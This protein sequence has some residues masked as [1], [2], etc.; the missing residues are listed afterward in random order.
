MHLKFKELQVHE[1]NAIFAEP[2]GSVTESSFGS[3]V[4]LPSEEASDCLMGV[5]GLFE[6]QVSAKSK[7]S[8]AWFSTCIRHCPNLV[9]L[10][11]LVISFMQNSTDLT[12]QP[13][14]DKIAS[15]VRIDLDD[16]LIL[17]TLIDQVPEYQCPEVLTAVLRIANTA[18]ATSNVLTFSNLCMKRYDF[19]SPV[20]TEE[21][22]MPTAL[23]TDGRI[24]VSDE[25]FISGKWFQLSTSLK[26]WFRSRHAPEPASLNP[27][28]ATD[29]AD[30]WGTAW[31][32]N[33]KKKGK[34]KEGKKVVIDQ[35]AI[36]KDAILRALEDLSTLLSSPLFSKC[37]QGLLF[38]LHRC[39]FFNGSYDRFLESML[40]VRLY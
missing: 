22:K 18:C 5:C 30:D 1:D 8:R 9:E 33:S 14:C 38:E 25:D 23:S 15:L 21:M 11:E 2:A 27:P 36:S 3:T 12:L 37:T 10:S 39:W 16:F 24:F 6:K 28:S 26:D 34:N 4:A 13:L 19:S 40:M 17:S 7:L 20:V 31:W 35:V 32:G 29:D